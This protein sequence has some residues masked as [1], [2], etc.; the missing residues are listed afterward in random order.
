MYTRPFGRYVLGMPLIIMILFFVNCQNKENSPSEGYS[1][2]RK[3]AESH[4][5]L[6][7]ASARE[8][9]NRHDFEDAKA[10]I[11]ELRKSYPMATTARKEALLLW[12]S[13]GWM[14]AEAQLREV[15]ARLQSISAAGQE[16]DSLQAEF[17]D[18]FN[19]VKF[20]K[21]KLNHDKQELR[22]ANAAKMVSDSE[23]GG[24]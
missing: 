1:E 19:R 17:E 14:E 23:E 11:K 16:K 18:L 21:R 22:D 12:D 20:Y 9:L 15:D 5:S 24:R 6:L 7:L 3:A 2:A 10:F 8:A 13:I 4:G